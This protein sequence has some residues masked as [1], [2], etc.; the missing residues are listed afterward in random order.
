MPPAI[1][2][3]SRSQNLALILQRLM[4][5]I[6]SISLLQFKNYTNRCF[7]FFR[8]GDQHLWQQR[9][10]NQ[11]AGCNSLSLFHQ[12]LLHQGRYQLC[13]AGK[14]GFRLEGNFGLHDKSEKA[15]CIL[16]ETGKKEFSINDQAYDKFSQHIGRYPCVVIAPDDAIAYNR[17]E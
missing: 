5:F 14:N 8:K 16:R 13:A 1:E 12:K 15:V 2:I 6:Q 3:Y 9:W 7:D 10:Q 4:L 17:R 11:P